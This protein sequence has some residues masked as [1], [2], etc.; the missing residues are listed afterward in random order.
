M[1]YLIDTS[2]AVAYLRNNREAQER[3]HTF[4]SEG[5]AT[6][7]IVVAE[8]FRGVFLS[9][10][11][12]KGESILEDFLAGVTV[13]GINYDIALVFGRE[14]ARLRRQGDQMGVL[15]LLIASTALHYDLTILTSDRDFERL[16]DLRTIFL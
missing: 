5:L 11:P 14:D 13:L 12:A 15:D 3:L 10:D 4:E 16:E 1:S 7:I 2:W 9:S 8:L 6:S